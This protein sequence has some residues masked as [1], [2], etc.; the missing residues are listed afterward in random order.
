[1]KDK[2]VLALV[3]GIFVAAAD[4]ASAAGCDGKTAPVNKQT[5]LF[6]KDGGV[7]LYAAMNINIDGSRRAYHRN[8][9]AGGAL[10]HLCVG[11]DV[12]LPNG[13][14]YVGS[15]DNPTCARFLRDY[16]KIMAAGWNDPKVGAIKWYG[17]L[18]KGAVTIKGRRIEGVVPVEQG[19][20]SG[21]YVSPTRLF[22]PG[23]SEVDQ[24]RYIEPLTVPA[25]VIRKNSDALT[26]AGVVPGSFGV[27]YNTSTK[28]AQPFIVGD[29][30]PR[31]G[32]GTPALAR[33]AAGLP[34]DP[35]IT[36][37]ERYKGSVES[38]GI[39]WVFFGKNT[40]DAP[41]D[42]DRVR[43]AAASAFEVWGGSSRLAT[44]LANRDVPKN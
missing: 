9:Y 40:L 43:K 27:A 18:G 1:M 3:A 19:D 11:G 28:L 6:L 31:I 42:A 16:K 39:L 38:P 26:K 15:K 29:T 20:G 24:R 22:D 36:K 21:Y 12:Y 23:F 33:L 35:N 2:F 7:A 5:A 30:G 17:L 10:L 4:V 41:Y 44:C 13:T 37:K 32:E 25:A 8:N 14:W 34:I